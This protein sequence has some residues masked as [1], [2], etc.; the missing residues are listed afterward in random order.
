V[1]ESEPDVAVVPPASGVSATVTIADK[2]MT[3]SWPPDIGDDMVEQLVYH[4][5]LLRPALLPRIAQCL[6]ATVAERSA[7]GRPP[8]H[9]GG[10]S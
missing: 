3:I 1:A 7:R 2:T 6:S 8:A 4:F 5:A 10:A 9:E